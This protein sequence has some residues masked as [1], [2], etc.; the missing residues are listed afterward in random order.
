MIRFLHK[1]WLRAELHH[2]TDAIADELERERNHARTMRNLYAI[3]AGLLWR[4]KG[5]PDAHSGLTAW[6]RERGAPK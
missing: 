3:R 2:I 1:L 5:G 6:P 4:I